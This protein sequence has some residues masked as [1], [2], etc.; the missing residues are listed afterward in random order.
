[1]CALTTITQDAGDL[2]STDLGHSVVANATTQILL[3]QAPQAI[4]QIG[5][6]FKLSTG[7]RR[8][9][10]TCQTGSGLLLCGEHRI[11]VK[12]VASR[13]EH[14]LATSDPA[15]LARDDERAAA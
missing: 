9:L 1:W 5:E 4:E 2:L 12:V 7:E 11:P 13:A 15:E 14:E 3:R 6:A 10:I 8:Y